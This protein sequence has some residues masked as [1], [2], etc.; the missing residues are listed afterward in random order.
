MLRDRATTEKLR[1]SDNAE[2][3]YALLT[4]GNGASKAA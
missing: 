3:L 4:N 2:A 1:G